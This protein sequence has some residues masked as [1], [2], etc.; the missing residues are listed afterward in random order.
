MWAPSLFIL[1][2][3][4]SMR[5]TIFF[6]IFEAQKSSILKGIDGEEEEEETTK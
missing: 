5:F 4:H 2:N 3:F 6:T 1:S